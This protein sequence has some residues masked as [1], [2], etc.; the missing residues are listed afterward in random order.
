VERECSMDGM[1]RSFDALYR[2]VLAGRDAPDP[3]SRH[4]VVGGRPRG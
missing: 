3:R 4:A 2:G 1:R